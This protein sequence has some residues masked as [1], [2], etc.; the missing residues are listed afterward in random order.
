MKRRPN[1]KPRQPY[2]TYE[3]TGTEGWV[4]K[5]ESRG[6]PVAYKWIATSREYDSKE[7]CEMSDDYQK[8]LQEF[9]NICRAYNRTPLTPKPWGLSCRRWS[10]DRWHPVIIMEWIP[11]K[12]IYF[13]KMSNLAVEQII[14]NTYDK[15]TQAGIFHRDLTDF[16]LMIHKGEVRVVDLSHVTFQEDE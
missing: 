4:T 5:D 10:K 9:E 11:G 6:V 7:S 8:A 14:R 12:P 1:G 16:N 13:S 2:R 15:L 3:R